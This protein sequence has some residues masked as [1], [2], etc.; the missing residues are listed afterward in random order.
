MNKIITLCDLGVGGQRGVVYSSKGLCM[1][2][3]ATQY[4][5]A[6]KIVVKDKRISKNKDE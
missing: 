6:P 1:T 4:K 3:S 5:D 2:L